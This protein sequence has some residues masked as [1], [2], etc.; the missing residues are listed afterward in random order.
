MSDLCD[1][2]DRKGVFEISSNFKL[3]IE[4][5]LDNKVLMDKMRN[6]VVEH[7]RLYNSELIINYYNSYV[8][9]F[10]FEDGQYEK[11]FIIESMI[12][13]FSD[14][15]IKDEP[16]IVFDGKTNVFSDDFVFK[17]TEISLDV[18]LM[19]EPYFEFIFENLYDI[20]I[21]KIGLKET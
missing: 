7:T 1:L 11:K 8:C 18:L 19:I 21:K 5:C 9:M 15:E 12:D 16:E 10:I 3:K 6:S 2:V 20:S 14:N 17:K 13:V 4:D